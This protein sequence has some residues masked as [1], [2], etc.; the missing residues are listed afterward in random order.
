MGDGEYHRVR[1]LQYVDVGE[2]NTVF[3]FNFAW[4]GKRIMH[5]YHQSV[6]AQLI[7]DVGDSG[8]SR[9]GNIFLKTDAENG[10]C[11]CAV[12]ALEQAPD[13]FV[14]DALA[15]AVVDLA[16]GQDDLRL[17]AG[18]LGPIRQIIRVDAN[19]VTADQ[20]RREFLEIPFRGGRCEHVTSINT[21]A[22]E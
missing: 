5:L 9:I 22:F 19:A 14:R 13:A 4:V 1:R 15:H 7:D 17:I 8:I 2:I 16:P 3:A 11:R 6:R 21:D 18:L 10:D 20:P 12:L